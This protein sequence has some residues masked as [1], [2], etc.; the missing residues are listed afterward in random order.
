MFYMCNTIIQ[1]SVCL[2]YVFF[3]MSFS[4]S[5]VARLSWDIR[6][7]SGKVFMENLRPVLWETLRLGNYLWQSMTQMTQMKKF[8]KFVIYPWQHGAKNSWKDLW[9]HLHES[10]WHECVMKMEAV[11]LA[12]LTGASKWYKR[13]IDTKYG[14]SFDLIVKLQS[15]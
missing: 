4:P 15:W 14:V 6:D 2:T 3:D 12:W 5:H 10:G 11:G 13:N 7:F 1:P 9:H 8:R